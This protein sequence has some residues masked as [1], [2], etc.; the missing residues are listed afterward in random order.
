MLLR[1]VTSWIIG[2]R[3]S[4][5]V[6]NIFVA[7]ML[8]LLLLIV[9]LLVRLGSLTFKMRPQARTGNIILAVLLIMQFVGSQLQQHSKTSEL[10]GL[11]FLTY[12]VGLIW[13]VNRHCVREQFT[14]PPQVR[15]KPM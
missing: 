9:I 14:E 2:F 11:V 1:G 10:L 4:P 3:G 6:V 5:A 15:C 12:G 8:L 7:A 13:Y